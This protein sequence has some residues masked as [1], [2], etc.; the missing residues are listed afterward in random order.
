M[1]LAAQGTPAALTPAHY[2]ARPPSPCRSY[3]S[4]TTNSIDG[5]PEEVLKVL[6]GAAAASQAGASSRNLG[7]AVEVPNVLH[8]PSPSA[9]AQNWASSK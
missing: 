3:N 9:A 5:H 6:G 2:T 4:A 1:A 8:A 7:K